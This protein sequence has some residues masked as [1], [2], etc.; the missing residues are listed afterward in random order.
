[1]I[2]YFDTSALIPLVV[3]EAGSERAG[4]V[5][6]EAERVVTVRI[7][8]PEGRAALARARHLGRLT[9]RGTRTARNGFED[10]WSQLDRVEVTAM[11]AQRAGDL[12]DQFALRGYDAVHL[13][14]AETLTD[15]DLVLVAGDGELC[16][17]AAA[18]GLAVART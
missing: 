14:A 13:A 16:A 3:Q 10:L 11:L 18:L 2:A 7:A 1:V 15:P 12:A 17:A 9:G 6:D 8:Y 4:R 5:W